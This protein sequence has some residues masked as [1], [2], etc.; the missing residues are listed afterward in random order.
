M[1]KTLHTV[2]ARNRDGGLV[3]S[4][5]AG[6]LVLQDPPRPAEF[7][8]R[9]GLQQD[10]VPS[11]MASSMGFIVDDYYA[12]VVSKSSRSSSPDAQCQPRRFPV[13]VY[14][15]TESDPIKEIS[16][17]RSG[18]STSSPALVACGPD[19]YRVVCTGQATGYPSIQGRWANDKVA[20]HD[21]LRIWKTRRFRKSAGRPREA[22]Y[23]RWL[24]GDEAEAARA[25]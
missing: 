7:Q 15:R 12:A 2:V 13:G 17:R 1:G 18:F 25:T 6:V 16:F 8:Q 14:S 23:I 24:G 21:S 9:L 22:R 5:N 19:G 3:E 20:F 10:S 11:Y 4:E